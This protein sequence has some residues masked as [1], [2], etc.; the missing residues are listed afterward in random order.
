MSSLSF[1]LTEEQRRQIRDAIAALT[2]EER[3]REAS[4]LRS[5]LLRE[6]QECRKKDN[7]SKAAHGRQK[8]HA[9]L[10]ASRRKGAEKA[11]RRRAAAGTAQ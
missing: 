7:A 1:K 10:E 9:D 4:R 11:R 3:H 8:Y 2:G 5:R 6:D